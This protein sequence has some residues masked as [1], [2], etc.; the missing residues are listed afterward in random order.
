[1]RLGLLAIELLI[2]SCWTAGA[3]VWFHLSTTLAENAIAALFAVLAAKSFGDGLAIL[4]DKGD[5]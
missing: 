5:G 1:M 4:L 3:V 2:F